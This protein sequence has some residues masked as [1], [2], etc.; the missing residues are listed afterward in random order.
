[1]PLPTPKPREKYKDFLS[2][3]LKNKE[4]KKEFPETKQRFAV[5]ASAWNRGRELPTQSEMIKRH[6][7][8]VKKQRKGL[9][10]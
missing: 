9:K 7:I 1:M 8:K 3:F 6:N 5:A 4:A 10:W 2:R